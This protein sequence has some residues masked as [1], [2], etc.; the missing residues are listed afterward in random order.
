MALTTSPTSKNPAPTKKATARPDS[1]AG[2]PDASTPKAEVGS[3]QRL[4]ITPDHSVAREL[5]AL[6]DGGY[7][8]YRN[9]LRGFMADPQLYPRPELSTAQQ[10]QHTFDNL[11]KVCEQGGFQRGMRRENGGG[12]QPILAT[13]TLE[14]L[15]WGNGS[16]AIKAGVQ[17][18]L[19]GGALD[20]LGTERHR[21][22]VEKAASLEL[23]GCFAMTE[24]G[25]GSDVQ[26]LETT[27]TYDPQTQE[28]VIH[29]PRDSAVKNY[30][31]NAA[32]DGRAAVVFAQLITPESDGRSNGVHALIVPLRDADGSLLPGVSAGDHGHKG[33]LLGVDNGTLRFDKVRVPRVNLLN[34]FADVDADGR[35]HSP[36]SNQNA[37]FFTMLGTLIRGRIGVAGAA[38]GATQ[39]AL[40]I[41]VRYATRRR[42]FEGATG[43]EKRLIEHRQHRRRLLI[44]LA[45][46]YA[47]H[48]LYV[49]ILERYQ[50]I[51]DEQEAG[52]WSVAEPTEAQ[53]FA[54]REMESLAA[55]IKTAQ[56]AH[57][58]STIQECR[59]ACGGAGYMSEN[60]LTTYR[61]DSDVFSTFEG[62][63]TVLIQMV[64]KNLLTAYGR[65][66]N[67]LS[68]WETVKYAATTA[69]DVVRRRAGFT[70]RLQRLRD[71][72]SE[73]EAASLFNPSYQAKLIDDRAQSVLFALV[74]RIQPAR[75]A[76][77]VQ[78]AAI[79]DQCQNHLIAAGWAR[80]DA[81]LI[82]AMVEAEEKLEEG[83]QAR[84]VFE[85]LRHLF[86]FD[87][88]VQHAGWYQEHREL[89]SGRIKAARAAIN[90]LVDSLGP[91]AEVLV[92]GFGLPA[93]VHDVP[94]LK[95]AGVDPL[96]R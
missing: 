87:T 31:G 23:P 29:T 1:G 70:T 96:L 2:P 94:M 30:I 26:N 89:P 25:H 91:W 13:F 35:Y 68:P 41:A 17:W 62:D 58:T 86:A 20:Q 15:A 8:D 50:E 52:K 84:Q 57:A 67:E 42:Q 90:D 39:A 66:M 77:R 73:T 7:G 85:Q 24:C 80:V 88:I 55:A 34:R 78:A 36:I 76:D 63:N 40:D 95:G 54:S 93:E 71:L 19:W 21:E 9:S 32:V 51:N 53:K 5:Q 74:R 33:G 44:P 11:S 43:A 69:S 46:T 83:S 60:R 14:S 6:L 10:R 59:E 81:L 64:G 82:Q 3:P 65:E 48:L 4:P 22:W 92:E 37:R 79:V 47:L 61:A 38:G 45:R 18:G 28:F 12:G 49:Q 27:A 56:T 75:K 72:V 16:L